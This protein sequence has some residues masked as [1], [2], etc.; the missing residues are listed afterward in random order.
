MSGVDHVQIW[1][2]FVQLQAA[3]PVL[4]KAVVEAAASADAADALRLLEEESAEPTLKRKPS[5]ASVPPD[6]LRSIH[7]FIDLHPTGDGTVVSDDG[8]FTFI[9][10]EVADRGDNTTLDWLHQVFFSRLLELD[11]DYPPLGVALRRAAVAMDYDRSVA[12]AE[13]WLF[14]RPEG[15]DPAE[16]PTL[17]R[18]ADFDR[19]MDE[20]DWRRILGRIPLLSQIPAGHASVDLGQLPP[21]LREG[22]DRLHDSKRYAKASQLLLDQAKAQDPN[23]DAS[24]HAR[25]AVARDVLARRKFAKIHMMEFG[26]PELMARVRAPGGKLRLDLLE[27]AVLSDADEVR[28]AES[29]QKYQD[30]ERLV[31]FLRI[32]PHMGDIFAEEFSTLL[33]AAGSTVAAGEGGRLTAAAIAPLPPFEDLRLEFTAHAGTEL[34]HPPNELDGRARLVGLGEPVETDVSLPVSDLLE[35]AARLVRYY[36]VARYGGGNSETRDLTL[37]PDWGPAAGEDAA[38]AIGQR[39]WKQTFEKDMRLSDRLT[40]ALERPEPVRLTISADSNWI[41]E[42]L[43]E[44]LYVPTIE[45]MA[46]HT[47]KMS[48][49]RH[50]PGARVRE[51]RALATPVRILIVHAA[52]GGWPLPGAEQEI[53]TLQRL[54]AR[55]EQRGEIRLNVLREASAESLQRAVRTFR[56]QI[57]HYVGHATAPRSDEAGLVLHDDTE[58]YTLFGAKALAEV[59]RDYDVVLAV[60][61]GCETGVE[62]VGLTHGICQT[63]IRAGVPAVIATTRAVSDTSALWFGRE[64]YRALMDGFSLEASIAEA[65]KALRVKKWDWSAY[66]FYSADPTKLGTFD[67]P[68]A[69]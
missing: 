37:V 14:E 12:E 57:L 18:D 65:R 38:V 2:K 29:W 28:L 35:S 11:N 61:N 56:P 48:V 32:R 66:A 19:R 55:A 5:F 31:D 9:V 17:L 24:V 7:Q 43:W 45:R 69:G 16:P 3:N 42:L 34:E 4:V 52:P 44:C 6:L 39:L 50:V 40:T 67:F 30:D 68:V 64:L 20:S 10:A 27:R 58:Q 51:T 15:A 59:L 22:V 47:I 46:G 36:R 33:A 23:F 21:A 1:R 26:W 13:Q 54:F 49:V 63:I 60:L 41:T 25:L 53:K 62:R 8:C